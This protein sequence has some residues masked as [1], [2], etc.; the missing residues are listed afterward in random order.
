MTTPTKKNRMAEHDI[1]IWMRA[2]GLRLVCADGRPGFK[3]S[4][5]SETRALA[6]V[7]QW[8]AAP[9]QAGGADTANRLAAEGFSLVDHWGE[10]TLMPEETNP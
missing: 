6:L 7:A 4:A 5:A 1:R 9:S 8:A 10:P 3:N 2:R